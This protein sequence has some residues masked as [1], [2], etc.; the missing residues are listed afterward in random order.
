MGF[1]YFHGLCFLQ[2]V[3]VTKIQQRICLESEP[4]VADTIHS[5]AERGFRLIIMATLKLPWSFQQIMEY[6]QY[7]NFSCEACW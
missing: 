6:L 1:F 4:K 2:K 7:L 5:S 3:R